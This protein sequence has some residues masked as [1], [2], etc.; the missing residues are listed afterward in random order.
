MVIT[1][2]NC[3]KESFCLQPRH[4]AVAGRLIKYWLS[5]LPIFGQPQLWHSVSTEN[6]ELFQGPVVHYKKGSLSVFRSHRQFCLFCSEA[7]L[8]KTVES[9]ILWRQTRTLSLF[10]YQIS[11]MCFLNFLTPK[12][13]LICWTILHHAQPVSHPLMPAKAYFIHTEIFLFVSSG[14]LDHYQ[15]V[16]TAYS[17]F[18]MIR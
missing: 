16:F 8:E 15:P 9:E 5:V 2:F 14:C 3:L 18:M 17:Q 10:W 12:W 11:Q 13:N 4:I 7:V 6:G 1:A